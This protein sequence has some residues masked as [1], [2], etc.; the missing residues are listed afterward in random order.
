MTDSIALGSLGHIRVSDH[1]AGIRLTWSGNNPED[2]LSPTRWPEDAINATGGSDVAYDLT[3]LAESVGVEVTTDGVLVPFAQVLQ[4]LEDQRPLATRWGTPS[5]FLLTIDRDGDPGV[6]GFRYVTKWC[7]GAEEVP[8]ERGGVYL[9]WRSRNRLYRLDPE[10]AGIIQAIED[11]NA[12]PEDDRRGTA[13][14]SAFGTIRSSAER[15]GI[16]L[17]AALRSN[18]VVIPSEIGLELVSHPDGSMSFAPRSPELGGPE[19]RTAFF[20]NAHVPDVY[21][22]S[23]PDG[24]RVRVLLQEKHREVLRRMK[25]VTRRPREEAER[26]ARTPEVVFD[27]VLGDVVLEYGNRVSGVGVID[28]APSPRDP[29]QSGIVGQVAP[30]RGEVAGDVQRETETPGTTD[31]SNINISATTTTGDPVSIPVNNQEAS[32]FAKT[33]IDAVKQG[34]TTVGFGDQQ[35]VIDPALLAQVS[36]HAR[37]MNEQDRQYLLIFEN[38]EI[39]DAADSLSLTQARE[40]GI[41]RPLQLPSSLEPEVQLKEHQKL[42]VQWLQRCA[43][44]PKRTGVLLADDMGLGKTL[45]VLTWLASAIEAGRLND[46][47]SSSRDG[48]FRPALVIAPLILVDAGTWTAEME[49]RFRSYGA[50]FRPWLVLHGTDVSKVMADTD[51]RDALNRPRL[52]PAKIMR[53]RV[54]ITTY[55]TLVNYQHSLAQLVNGRSMWSIVVT[56][57]AQRYKE[58]RTKVSHAIKALSPP[59]HIASTGT[60]VENRLLD[61]WNIMDSVQPGLLGTAREFSQRYESRLPQGGGNTADVLG[62]LRR[63]LFFGAPNAFLLRRGKEQLTD[64]PEKTE[65]VI[66]CPMSEEEL[67]HEVRLVGA[68]QQGAG[69]LS[70]QVLQELA[71]RSQ[72]PAYAG[73]ELD[74]TRTAELVRQSTKLTEL[75]RLLREIRGRGEK[76]LVFA[77]HV[78]IQQ[79]LSAAISKEFGVDVAIVNGS[80]RPGGAGNAGQHRRRLLTRFESQP[81]FGVIV[82]SP[83]VAGVGLTITAANHVVHYGRWWNPAVESQATDRAYRI[84]QVKPVTVYYLV[85]RAPRDRLPHGTFDEALHSLISRRRSL[86]RDFLHPERSEDALAREMVDAL[87][88]ETFAPIAEAKTTFDQAAVLAVTQRRLGWTPV[89]FEKDGHAG[90]TALFVKGATGQLLPAAGVSS[91]DAVASWSHLIPELRWAPIE[92]S[93][94]QPVASEADARMERSLAHKTAASGIEAVRQAATLSS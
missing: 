20:N 31:S 35:I 60:P 30:S 75:M 58:M 1:A 77:R 89:L 78:A 73:G 57:E 83:F 55:E 11:F 2:L 16:Q 4:L 61:L 26:L 52:D 14:W 32:A 91:A 86:A 38:D 49:S 24:R 27:G 90:A 92:G 51:D 68:L 63:E 88:A 42:G 59:F 46:G 76:V 62:D 7:L 48:P 53:Y 10:T 6:R 36:A 22:I 18:S 37:G 25:R 94:M 70:L 33:I 71:A 66:G 28:F 39:L 47:N 74:L 54:V 21:S 34:Q 15:L 64:L 82:L 19:F 84:G 93:D 8:V 41:A 43:E 50:V 56:D 85:S 72:H 17:D 40:L 80:T 81:G 44:I 23:R 13:M 69:R 12:L 5:P 29:S 3:V 65:R 67:R 87:T 9:K 79:L 45:Q